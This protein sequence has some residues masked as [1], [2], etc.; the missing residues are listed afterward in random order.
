M[1]L[2]HAYFAIAVAFGLTVIVVSFL[3]RSDD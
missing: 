2:G 1:T 3:G